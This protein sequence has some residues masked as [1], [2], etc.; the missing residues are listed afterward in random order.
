MDILTYTALALAAAACV[1]LLASAVHVWLDRSLA[2]Q[3]ADTAFCRE[4]LADPVMNNERRRACLMRTNQCNRSLAA[5]IFAEV[6]GSV[7][8]YVVT[9]SSQLLWDL[10]GLLI[11]IIFFLLIALLILRVANGSVLKWFL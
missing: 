4:E 7:Y 3:A 11:L 10:W 8:A 5:L 1:Y 2:C 6:A 9:V